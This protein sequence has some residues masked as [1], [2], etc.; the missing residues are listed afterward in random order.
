MPFFGTSGRRGR[1]TKKWTRAVELHDIYG[2]NLDVARDDTPGFSDASACATIRSVLACWGVSRSFG[3]KVGG[4]CPA[5]RQRRTL[6][7]PLRLG[8]A[9]PLA[10]AATRYRGFCNPP[11]S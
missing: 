10:Y 5:K 6:G 2:G 8:G 4:P 3:W 9:R 11:Q 7:G 1:M